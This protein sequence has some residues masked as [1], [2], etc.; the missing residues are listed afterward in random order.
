MQALHPLKRV[1]QLIFDGEIYSLA[2]IAAK[3]GLKRTQ[4]PAPIAQSPAQSETIESKTKKAK[5]VNGQ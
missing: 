3:N 2:W 1:V 4:P 5:A